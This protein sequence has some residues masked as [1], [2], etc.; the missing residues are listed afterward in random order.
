[1]VITDDIIQEAL[2]RIGNGDFRFGTGM[3]LRIEQSEQCMRA[4][5]KKML[6]ES[7]IWLPQ[8]DRIADWLTDNRGRGLLLMGNCGVGKT[9][10]CC[11]VIPGIIKIQMN[12]VFFPVSAQ[13][14]HKHMPSLMKDELCIVDDIGIEVP[15]NEY[16]IRHNDFVEL[17]ENAENTKKVL[18]LTTNLNSK[19][20]TE[21][22]GER[23][24]DRLRVLVRCIQIPG[25]SLR[26]TA[27]VP[28]V[29]ITKLLL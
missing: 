23:V 8:Y 29:D 15:G 21:R 24:V 20:L 12:K 2:D 25:N 27:G 18:I 11:Y 14:I 19:E 22:Y 13:N 1:M 16:G 7:Y 4:F 10:M 26:G 6:G 5:L 3:I 28:D 9:L 17:V